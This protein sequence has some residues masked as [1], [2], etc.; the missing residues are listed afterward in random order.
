MQG[1]EICKYFVLA[2][3]SS[4]MVFICNAMHYGYTALCIHMAI[5][6]NEEVLNRNYRSVVLSWVTTAY[7]QASPHACILSYCN[8]IQVGSGDCNFIA[9]GLTLRLAYTSIA[10]AVP[11]QYY[12]DKIRWLQFHWALPFGCGR[13]NTRALY[14][15]DSLM[16]ARSS[17]YQLCLQ[18]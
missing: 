4:C 11:L 10:A 17:L 2:T 7:C 1:G 12:P 15:Y 13:H 8:I 16:E 18:T 6:Q 5:L 3:I 9:M 14:S